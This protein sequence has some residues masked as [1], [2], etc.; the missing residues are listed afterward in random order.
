M[1]LHEF[2]DRPEKWTRGKFARNICGG[3]VDPDSPAAVS[4]C[5]VGALMKIYGQDLKGFQKHYNLLKK[6]FEYPINDNDKCSDFNSFH[7]A[8]KKADV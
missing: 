5:G 7:T 1:K 8:L 6:V 4:W 2:F 3:S